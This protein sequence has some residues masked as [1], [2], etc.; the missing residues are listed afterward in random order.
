MSGHRHR[1]PAGEFVVDSDR[2]HRDVSLGGS[3]QYLPYDPGD[4]R[5]LSVPA[6]RFFVT[7]AGRGEKLNHG[8]VAMR[9]GLASI[10]SEFDIAEL[11]QLS[12]SFAEMADILEAGR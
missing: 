9:V 3:V 1:D 6:E 5:T 7:L 12:R 2:L 8:I 11:R 10:H 4:A